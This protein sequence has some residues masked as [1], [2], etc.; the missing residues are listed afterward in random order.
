MRK[1]INLWY[2]LNLEAKEDFIRN[3]EDDRNVKKFMILLQQIK[4]TPQKSLKWIVI[5]FEVC[6]I[7]L[8]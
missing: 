7:L 2:E 1:W 5:Q 8:M 3:N 6:H 4:L